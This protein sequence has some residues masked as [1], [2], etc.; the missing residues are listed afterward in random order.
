MEWRGYEKEKGKKG[1]HELERESKSEG[2]CKRAGLK[3][4]GNGRKIKRHGIKK[5]ERKTT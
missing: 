1:T 4:A 3:T 5:T 2:Q